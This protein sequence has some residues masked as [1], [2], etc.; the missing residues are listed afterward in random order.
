MATENN[1]I[2]ITDD[3]S[4]ESVLKPKLVLLREI[5]SVSTLNY[6]EAFDKVKESFP[7]IVLIY[8]SSQKDECLELIKKISQD[9]KT[10]N[11][12]VLLV[13]DEYD[14]DFILSAYDENI[15][16]YVSVN[17]TEAELLMRVMWCFKKNSQLRKLKKQS[18]LLERLNVIDKET[19]FFTEKNAK[20]I[21]ENEIANIKNI[22]ES[23]IFMMVSLS[24]ESK[25]KITLASFAKAIKKSIRHSD[26]VIHC[27]NGRFF[28][29][30]TGTQVKWAFIVAEKIKKSL[31]ENIRLVS[32]VSEMSEKPFEQLNT[33]LLNALCEAET[34]GS[35]LMI[36]NNDELKS[37]N[38]SDWLSKMNSEQ[39]N[40]KL[41]KQ[42]FSKKLEKVIAPTFFQ[43]QKAYEENLFETVIEQYCTSDMSEFILKKESSYAEL[44]ITYPGFSKINI[45]IIYHGLDTPENRRIN[46]DLTELTD[47]SLTQIIEDFIQEFKTTF[48]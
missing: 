39:K 37:K 16:D 9:R 41:F 11:I 18:Q 12:S 14:E 25:T 48:E 40:F 6:T 43:L 1:I 31:G 4:V 10:K 36:L 8:C 19:G 28:I 30:L 46:L 20:D 15:A 7:E 2:L 27:A 42:A 45:D 44:K 22:E 38:D 13:I 35:D 21:F 32:S 23:A 47:S 33:E 17:S 3:K 24:E 34:S 5:D 29:I 26:M